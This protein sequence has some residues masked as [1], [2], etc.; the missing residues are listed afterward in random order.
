MYKT[1]K[2]FFKPK[3]NHNHLFLRHFRNEEN[4]MGKISQKEQTDPLRTFDSLVSIHD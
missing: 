4:G 3:K 1:Y 2:R